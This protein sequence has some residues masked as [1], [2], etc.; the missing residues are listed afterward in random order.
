MNDM[1]LSIVVP[2]FNEE[3]SVDLLYERITAAVQDSN[4]E[5][6][7]LFVDDGSQ[8]RTLERAVAISRS[9]P[10]LRVVEFRAN[11]GQ[12]PAMAAGIDLASGRIIATMDGD[13]QND[14]GDIPGML[15]EMDDD[16]HMVVGWRKNRQDKLITRKVPSWIANWLIGKVTGVPIRDNGCSLKLYRAS[17]IKRVPLYAEMHRF[18]PAMASITGAHVKE[19]AV[20]HHARQFGSSK[21]GLSRIYKV[22]LD[23]LSIKT[24]IGF[25]QRPLLWFGILAIPC[26][27]ASTIALVYAVAPVF[28]PGGALV[29]PYVGTGILYGALAIFLI[30]GGAVAELVYATGDIDLSGFAKL[31]AKTR[32]G[33]AR[34][35][36]IGVNSSDVD[37]GRR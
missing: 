22:L 28:S 14:P 19:R 4:V 34:P 27:I 23:L 33:A 25:S 30:L 12:T 9:D 20:T 18:I 29:L 2:L 13:L 3:D 6:E 1:D 5:Y 16:T 36:S 8:D 21:Y 11:Y 15:E 26:L 35:D 7:I 24:I 10:R 31:L 37:Y 32:V 17:V